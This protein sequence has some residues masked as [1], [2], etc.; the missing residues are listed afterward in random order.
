VDLGVEAL[1]QLGFRANQ[2]WRAGQMFKQY[3]NRL[4][5]EQ[6]NYLDDEHTYINKSL[7]Y[8]EILSDLLQDDQ[9][10]QERTHAHNWNSGLPDNDKEAI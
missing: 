6:V 5:R 3:D 7:Q 8:R 1:T 10:G 9:E 4:L 2:A